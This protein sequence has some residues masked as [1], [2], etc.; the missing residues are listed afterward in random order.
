[1]LNIFSNLSINSL[2][3]GAVV[4][5]IASLFVGKAIRIA[6]GAIFILIIIYLTYTKIISKPQVST[7]FNTSRTY[8]T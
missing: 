1:M 2:I 7:T 8:Q 6:V 4:G 5:L 3:I